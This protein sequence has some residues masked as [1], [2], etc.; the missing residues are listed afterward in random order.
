[1]NVELHKVLKRPI[2]T[3]KSTALKEAKGQVVFEV[4]RSATKPVIK[5]AVE[6]AFQV[7]VLDVNTMVVRGKFKRFG[8]FEGKKPNW[9]KAVVTLRPGDTIEV[10]EGV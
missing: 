3:E 4:H 1:M 6:K 10:I 8:R 7:K 5:A 9:K 2:V